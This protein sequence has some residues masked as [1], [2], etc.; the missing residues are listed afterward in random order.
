[1]RV[2]ETL[3]DGDQDRYEQRYALFLGGVLCGRFIRRP[4]SIPPPDGTVCL[5]DD[6]P[7]VGIAKRNTAGVF[8]GGAWHGLRFQPTHWTAFDEE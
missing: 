3:L 6:G 7:R 8:E 2:T 5:V 1:M 4:V